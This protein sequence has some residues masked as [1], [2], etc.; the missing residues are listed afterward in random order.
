[1]LTCSHPDGRYA[2]GELLVGTWQ[3]AE[4]PRDGIPRDEIPRDEI[5]GVEVSVLWYTEGKG[6]EDLA[7]HFFQRWNAARLEEIDVTTPQPFQTE[8]PFSPLTYQGHLLRIRWC[9]RLRLFLADGRD[10]VTEL[11][12]TLSARDSAEIAPRDDR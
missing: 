1:M 10:L 5:Q 4:A 7:V 11:P 3:L 2:P 9:L 12:L 8:L 6:D